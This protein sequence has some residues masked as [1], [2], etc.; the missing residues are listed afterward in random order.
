MNDVLFT[1]DFAVEDA[2]DINMLVCI[3][4]NKCSK[5]DLPCLWCMEVEQDTPDSKIEK[6]LE[7]VR[8]SYL[9]NN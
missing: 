4:P 8:K 6:F 7:E 5:E 2:D 9:T 1:P 3:Y